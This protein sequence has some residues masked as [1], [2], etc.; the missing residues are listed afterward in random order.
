MGLGYGIELRSRI[1]EAYDNGEG[2]VRELAERFAV[3]PNTV[4]NYL[5]LRKRTGGLAP[6]PH[7][8]GVPPRI[9]DGHLEDVRRLVQQSPD[10]TEG[11]LAQRYSRGHHV[12]LSR[13]TMGRALRRLGL[14]RK[15]KLSTRPSA[16]PSACESLEP[17]SG[18]RPPSAA[19]R[20]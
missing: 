16:T 12:E 17:T 14:T 2:S 7:S 8:G 13:Q 4:Q 20:R 5:N 15:K 9:D 18:V 11:D 19:R 1:V 10:A 3:A 6:L